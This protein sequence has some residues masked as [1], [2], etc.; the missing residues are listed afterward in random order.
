MGFK[1]F[2]DV[3]SREE[4]VAAKRVAIIGAGVAGL[5]TARQLVEAGIDCVIF[6]KARDV[7]GVWRENYDDF[8]LQVP[9]E[10]YEFPGFPYPKD[11]GVDLFPRGPQ[12]QRYIQSYAEAYGLLRLIKF[13]TL[14]H[15]L[16]PLT[17]KRGWA[18][19]FE[20]EGNMAV[21]E[22]DYCVMSTGMY[23]G[24]PHLPQH[25][26]AESFK[27][28]IL[29]SCTFLDKEQVKGKRVVVVGGGKSAVDNAVSAAKAG[30]SSTLLY[31]EAHWPVPRYLLNLIPFKWGT[32][33]RLGHFMLHASHDMGP[34][35]TWIHAVLAPL[36]WLFWRI[37]ELMF[38]VQFRLSGDAVPE[39]PI[40]VDLFTGGQILTYEYRNMLKAGHVRGVL[41]GET[42]P[43]KEF[44]ESTGRQKGA[45]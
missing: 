20:H 16:E 25:K 29:H 4:F 7:G 39:I 1:I 12:V 38:R 14:V 24:H 30:V 40:E 26:G 9:K 2:E 42:P 15:S 5:Q 32:Y 44:P 22:F 6:E 28:E 43:S 37:V 3:C 27:G 45:R 21:E 18:V 17:D 11:Q 34:V 35:A 19:R 13:G 23:S 31:R 36:K 33:S 41:R 10:L 8:G